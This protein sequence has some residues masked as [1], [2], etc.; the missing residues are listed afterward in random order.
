[1]KEQPKSIGEKAGILFSRA[2]DHDGDFNREQATLEAIDDLTKAEAVEV[3]QA[4]FGE[5]TRRQRTFLYFAREHE[6][7]EKVE[8]S[9][10]DLGKWKAGRQFR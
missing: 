1:M 5:E 7:K 3:F 4:M 8:Q 6:A 9:F 2:Y 10:D